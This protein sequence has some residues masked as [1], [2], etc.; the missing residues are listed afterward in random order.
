RKDTSKTVEWITGFASDVSAKRRFDAAIMTGHAFQCLL[1]DQHIVTLL[2]DVRERLHIG[3]SFWFESRNPAAEAWHRWTPDHTGPAIKLNDGRSVQVV[4]EVLD[5]QDG[6]VTFQERY[7]FGQ[8]LG[9]KISHSTLRFLDL[10]EITAFAVASGFEVAATFG[11]WSR[12]PV[13]DH[14]PEIIVRLVRPA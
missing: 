1:D 8:G 13:S 5:V 3:G 2:G 12:A 7:E 11:D 14:S 4:H 10:H 6:R 9:T